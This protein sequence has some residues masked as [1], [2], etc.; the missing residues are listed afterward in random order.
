MFKKI[1]I[2]PYSTLEIRFSVR[3]SKRTV[4]WKK[5]SENEILTRTFAP[6]KVRKNVQTS[7]NPHEPNDKCFA[8]QKKIKI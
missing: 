5:F 8:E 1:F 7:E 6:Q 3:I 2:K 4:L